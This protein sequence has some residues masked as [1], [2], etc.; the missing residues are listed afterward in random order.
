[1]EV[2]VS[3]GFLSLLF[4]PIWK[5]KLEIVKHNCPTVSNNVESEGRQEI[6]QAIEKWEGESGE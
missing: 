4:L 1:V 6:R 5:G 2:E 3:S